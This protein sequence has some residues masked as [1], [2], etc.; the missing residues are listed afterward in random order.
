MKK[1]FSAICMT[2]VAASM[3]ASSTFAWFSL[4]TTVKA[5]DMQVT[6][7]SDNTY[8]LISSTKESASD[9]QTENSTTATLT[10]NEAEAKVFPCAPALGDT[11]VGYLTTSGKTVDGSPITTAGV[12]VN[13]TA[14][15]AA[16]TN[17]Y[18][19]NALASN[20]AAIDSSSAKQ[21]TNFTGYVIER[22]VYLT[23][24]KGANAA[25]ELTV[26]PT[27]TQKNGGEDIT[28]A[29]ALITTSDG[30]FAVLNSSSVAT[31]IQGSSNI[32]DST[33]ITVNIYIYYDGND[34]KVFTNNKEK[35]KG[36]DLELKFDVKAVSG[37]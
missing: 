31:S 6:A 9:I 3:F 26:T 35:L 22:T 27:F 5:T 32:T 17:W 15:A 8:L 33:V 10:V 13:N 20:A 12:K 34:V 37:S 7:K 21:L 29:R 24:A 36:A 11:E 25:N 2:L 14:T 16:A 1:L 18:T 19:A 30:G 23:V 28:A 4:N